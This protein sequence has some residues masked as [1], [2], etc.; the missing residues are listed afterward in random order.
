[1]LN[2]ELIGAA[3]EHLTCTY[4]IENGWRSVMLNA[5]AFDIVAVKNGE[6]I[7][8]QVKTTLQERRLNSFQ[9]SISTGNKRN[10]KPIQVGAC[11]LVVLVALNIK[12]ALFLTVPD[13]NNQVTMRKKRQ[14]MMT[15]NL[16]RDTLERALEITS[17]SA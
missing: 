15:E 8:V 7:R 16:E 12:R 1:L 13:L 3:G 6:H 11:D 9:W 14:Y 5:E 17:F 10:K 4:L 2:S